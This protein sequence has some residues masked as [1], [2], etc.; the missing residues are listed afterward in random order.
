VRSRKAASYRPSITATALTARQSRSPGSS[1]PIGPK[2]SGDRRAAT[3][4]LASRRPGASENTSEWWDIDSSCGWLYERCSGAVARSKREARSDQSI[5]APGHAWAHSPY[6]AAPSRN[7]FQRPC[8]KRIGSPPRRGASSVPIDRPEAAPG[9]SV[10]WSASISLCMTLPFFIPPP[11]AARGVWAGRL[12][13][14]QT[15]LCS[16]FAHP[17]F[18]HPGV[19]LP[20]CSCRPAW[21]RASKMRS[22]S[23]R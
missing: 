18:A 17:G 6:T 21:R 15:A 23:R 11:S 1:R 20:Y 13:S 12:L 9:I 4:R 7:A 2:A 16:F 5:R 10:G 8:S 22:F 14:G 19:V 3:E